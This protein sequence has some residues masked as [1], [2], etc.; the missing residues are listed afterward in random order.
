[1][2]HTLESRIERAKELHKSGYN[3]SQ[4]V[5]MVFD[6]VTGLDSDTAARMSAGFGGGVGGQ[7]EVCGA[8]SGMAMVIGMCRYDTP[9]CKPSLYKTVQ[10]HCNEF[11]MANGSIVCGELLKPGRKPCISLIADA[12]TIV[13]NHLSDSM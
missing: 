5:A 13:H 1:M 2:N 8:V 4:C 3:C 6:D 10:E 9:A 11:R 12:I 7:R